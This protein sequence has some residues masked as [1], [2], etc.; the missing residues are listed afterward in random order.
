MKETAGH[1]RP[2][3]SFVLRQGRIT[4]AQ[5]TALHTLWHHYGVECVGAPINLDLLFGRS[6]PRVLE[7]GF[8]MGDALAAMA[9]A[10]PEQDYLGIEVHRPGVGNLL[11]LLAEQQSSN[12]HVLCGDAVEM[13]HLDLPDAA[14]DA[15][16]LFFPDPWPKRRHHKRRIVQPAFAALIAKKLRRGGRFHLCTD[17]E[18]YA[19]QMLEV[20]NAVPGLVNVSPSGGYADRSERPLS[21]FERRAVREGRIVRDLMFLGR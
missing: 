16:H 5:R 2:V 6:A 17:W 3:R 9:Q 18:E 14:F 8:G 10:H 4:T 7:I 15:V 20:L 19:A 13:L 11:R 1:I 21:K 12:A